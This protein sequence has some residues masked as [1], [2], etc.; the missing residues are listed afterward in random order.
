MVKLDIAAKDGKSY[1]YELSEE[2]S[3]GL[4]GKKIG[5]KISGDDITADLAGYEFQIS[6]LSDSRGFPGI[7]GIKG[8]NVK[9]VLLSYGKG[10]KQRRPKGMRRKKSVHGE[11]IAQDV[12]QVNLKVLKEGQKKLAEIFAKEKKESK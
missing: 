8:G 3:K 12:V 2:K 9:R 4:I 6:G 1:H 7:K 5:D 11:E 10:M